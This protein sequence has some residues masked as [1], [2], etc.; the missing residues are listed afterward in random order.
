MPGYTKDFYNAFAENSMLSASKV[1]PLLLDLAEPRS[2]LDVGCGVGAWLSIFKQNGVTHIQGVDGP[3]VDKKSLL[4]DENCFVSA[5]LEQ[6]WEL[7]RTYELVC[8]LEVA[9]HIPAAHAELFVTNLIRHGN[10]ILFSAAVPGQGGVDH[11]NEQWPDYWIEIFG[12]FG[13]EVFDWIRWQVWDDDQIEPWYR[14]N[15]FLFAKR[16]RIEK[17]KS[18]VRAKTMWRDSPYAVVHPDQYRNGLAERQLDY[19]G[20][21]KILAALPALFISAIRR[22]LTTNRSCGL[23]E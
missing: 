23:E 17:L 10:I 8:S 19:L 9:E 6:A 2:V 16:E 13:L 22:R 12:R 11:V 14:Q 21:K 3:W 20:L 1:V 4:I 5:N 7:G 15:M 18:R